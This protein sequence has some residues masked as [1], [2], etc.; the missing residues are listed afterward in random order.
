MI[1]YTLGFNMIFLF[2]NSCICPS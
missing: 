1:G 2:S